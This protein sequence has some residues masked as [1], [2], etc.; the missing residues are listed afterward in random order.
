[1]TSSGGIHPGKVSA[2]RRKSTRRYLQP[3]LFSCLHRDLEV[4]SPKLIISCV[5]HGEVKTSL[6]S[7]KPS[8]GGLSVVRWP[9]QIVHLGTPPI[10]IIT[11]IPV[12]Q[13]KMTPTC[14]FNVLYHDRYG[15]HSILLC[16]S[17]TS[18]MKLM[19]CKYQFN[20]SFLMLPQKQFSIRS[21][22]P[23]GIYEKPGTTT[24]ST[25]SN[26]RQ[27]ESIRRFL[28]TWTSSIKQPSYSNHSTRATQ[29]IKIYP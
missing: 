29:V 12:E 3:M 21:Y 8:L 20:L 17:P 2:P 9:L 10:E 13:W 15:L 16:L 27:H 22:L 14:S 18:Q 25:G 6:L 23:C 5:V 7:S 4:F 11:V 28:L 26:G 1:M 24:I 19:V